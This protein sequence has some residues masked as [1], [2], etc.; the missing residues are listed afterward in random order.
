MLPLEELHLSSG[1]FLLG[2]S[3]FLGRFLLERE[4][5]TPLPNAAP[6]VVEHQGRLDVVGQRR[7]LLVAEEV[8]E[9]GEDALARCRIGADGEDN[10]RIL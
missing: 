5:T 4:E 8:L 2:T 7:H 1:I 9:E 6:V 3:I 10:P